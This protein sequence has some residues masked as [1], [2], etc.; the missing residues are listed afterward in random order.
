MSFS[1]QNRCSWTRARSVAWQ[2]PSWRF[3]SFQSSSRRSPCDV[4]RTVNTFTKRWPKAAWHSL[5]CGINTAKVVDKAKK[6]RSCPHSF[7]TTIVNTLQ[8]PKPPCIFTENPVSRW[9]SIG[10]N[11]SFTFSPICKVQL[12]V[13]LRTESLLNRQF[14]AYQL[15]IYYSPSSSIQH[16]YTRRHYHGTKKFFTIST[17]WTAQ[18]FH[19]IKRIFISCLEVL[20]AILES[21]TWVF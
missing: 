7:V 19:V 20:H 2:I 14:I 8:P 12:N 1:E 9:K 10:P 16:Y 3:C 21:V 13:K 11:V 17:D 15:S 5:Y 6:S 18:K 4:F